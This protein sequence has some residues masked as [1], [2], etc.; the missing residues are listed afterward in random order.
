MSQAKQKR[1]LVAVDELPEY[2]LDK[3]ERLES[4]WFIN[5][6][7]NRWLNSKFKLTAAPEVRAYAFDLFCI[8]QNQ[9][10]VG[11]LPDD[12]RQ[13]SALLGLDLGVWHD[14]RKREVSPLYNWTPCTCGGTEVRLM[15]PTVTEVALDA[16][17]KKKKN[18][19]NLAAGRERRRMNTLRET[20]VKIG[21]P[22]IAKD[23]AMLLRVKAWLVENVDGNWTEDW[24]RQALEAISG[25]AG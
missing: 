11:T 2:P 10:P 21:A 12:D 17:S 9:I 15:H 3:K 19:D 23:G 6:H 18:A 24:V 5:F 22:N 16:F 1:E 14:L 13:L 25:R 20:I 7:F 4:H 8:A